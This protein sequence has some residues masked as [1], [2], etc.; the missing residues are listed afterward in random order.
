MKIADLLD[1]LDFVSDFTYP[2]LEQL[3]KFVTHHEMEKGSIIFEE[4]DP[5]DFLL[6]VVQGR[7][8]IFKGGE[9]G[10]QLL[11]T[12]TCGRIVGEMAMIDQER[13][14]ATCV[15]E[16][17]C[18]LLILTHNNMQSMAKEHPAVAYHFMSSLARILSR[19]LRR[20]SGMMADFLEQ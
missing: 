18:E 13:R 1:G 19:R 11:S 4:G 12:E 16:S 3:A 2:E 5:G 9:H 20:T 6:I 7:I 14:S 8:S 15:S 10:H 17:V